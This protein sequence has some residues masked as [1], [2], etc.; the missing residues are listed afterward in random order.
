MSEEVHKTLLLRTNELGM[1]MVGC[2]ICGLPVPHS[3]RDV[4]IESNKMSD[5][6]IGLAR[7][8]LL[9][10][11]S[12][13]SLDYRKDLHELLCLLRDARVSLVC[14]LYGSPKQLLFLYIEPNGN[15]AVFLQEDRL[16]K[17]S[18]RMGC[19]TAESLCVELI[20]EMR[21]M[22][23]PA[24]PVTHVTQ[25]IDWR[26]TFGLP[27]GALGLVEYWRRNDST[28]FESCLCLRAHKGDCVLYKNAEGNNNMLE[29][30]VSALLLPIKEGV[31]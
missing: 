18:L 19:G 20:E 16:K 21:E 8:G 3:L 27:S 12:E 13:A 14:H 6:I 31:E 24:E 17:S 22:S 2:D 4:A 1:L 5:A 28:P 11:D 10:N 29:L 23:V 9:R 30:S 7:D 25:R 26:D 15:K